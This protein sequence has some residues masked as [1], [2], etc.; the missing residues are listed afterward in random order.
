MNTPLVYTPL[1][2][3]L[4]LIKN[5]CESQSNNNSNKISKNKVGKMAM[6]KIISELDNIDSV[7][8]AIYTI[9]A[10]VI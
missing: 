1:F 3:Q 2:T 5:V 6:N 9:N 4:S 8:Y 10:Y 7:S